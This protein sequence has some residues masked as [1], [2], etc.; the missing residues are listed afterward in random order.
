MNRDLRTKIGE[1]LVR[2]HLRTDQVAI[3]EIV[4]LFEGQLLEILSEVEKVQASYNEP[5]E[6]T[7]QVL[8]LIKKR[9][10]V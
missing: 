10:G 1:I 3:G 7:E 8:A 6:I 9:I 2:N 5:C 4:Q